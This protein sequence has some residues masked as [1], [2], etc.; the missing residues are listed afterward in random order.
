MPLQTVQSYQ[1][2]HAQV[3]GDLRP[4]VSEAVLAFVS[5]YCATLSRAVDQRAVL[6]HLNY[7]APQGVLDPVI[8]EALHEIDPS[9][10]KLLKQVQE[11]EAEVK[12]LE[13]E[14][15][16][17]QE[18]ADDLEYD[19]GKQPEKDILPIPH[20]LTFADIRDAFT[21]GMAAM[22]GHARAPLQEFLDTL[23]ALNA[24]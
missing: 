7:M 14:V 17:I 4:T 12:H 22:P 5:H 3:S 16:Q 8:A 24:Q 10:K 15:D 18:Y 23:E 20:G 6:S 1:Y 11:L 21:Y 19:C 9:H 13:G 2:T